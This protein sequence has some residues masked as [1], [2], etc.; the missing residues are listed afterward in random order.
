MF[1]QD[2]TRFAATPITTTNPSLSQGIFGPTLVETANRLA[3]GRQP[4]HRRP[5]SHFGRWLAAH[6]GRVAPDCD[7]GRSR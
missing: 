6:R 3:H 4:A 5:S 2:I 1:M 7:P